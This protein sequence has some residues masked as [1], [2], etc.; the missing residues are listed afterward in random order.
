MVKDL[1]SLPESQ[2][3]LLKL[4]AKHNYENTRAKVLSPNGDTDTFDIQAGVLHPGLAPG[5]CKGTPC[6]TP[7]L[8]V[9][10]LELDY[11]VRMASVGTKKILVYTVQRGKAGE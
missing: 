11:A 5:S 7:Y 6:L 4:M 2:I 9:I 10:V 8:F 1:T 3:R